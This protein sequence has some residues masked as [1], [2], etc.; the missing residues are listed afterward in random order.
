MKT[1]ELDQPISSIKD[2]HMQLSSIE[3]DQLNQMFQNAFVE[4]QKKPYVLSEGDAVNTLIEGAR[5]LLSTH[6]NDKIYS[7]GRSPLWLVETARM[8]EEQKK[9]GSG[10]RMEY[11]AFSGR[12]YEKKTLH[13]QSADNWSVAHPLVKGPVS[14]NPEQI[15]HFRE[16]LIGIG[17]GPD[18]VRKRLE[19]GQKTVIVER[20]HSGESLVSFLEIIREWHGYPTQ[21]LVIYILKSPMMPDLTHQIQRACPGVSVEIHPFDH[22][23]GRDLANSD[24][25][26][27]S[28]GVHY[29]YWKWQETQPP[30]LAESNN[31]RT[32]LVRYKIL[33]TINS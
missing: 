32:N 5:E 15:H 8:L 3:K 11:V 10:S 1:N 2:W 6:P 18:D 22:E 33:D 4:G 17:L 20:T 28:L 31:K 21:G 12:W 7:L 9:K 30:K 29:P 14:P 24:S 13:G 16:Y 27:D 23:V 26:Q 25:Y 19:Q